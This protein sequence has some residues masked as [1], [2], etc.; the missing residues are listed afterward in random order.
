VKIKDRYNIIPLFLAAAL[1]ALVLS[2]VLLVY[3]FSRPAHPAIPLAISAT[4]VT[5]PE[6]SQGR[7]EATPPVVVPEPEPE[8][9]E[10][11][12]PVVEPPPLV[13]PEPAVPDPEIEKRRAAEEQKRLEDLRTEQERIRREKADEEK[14]K[15]DAE[16]ERKKREE[17]EQKKRDEAE[18]ERREQEAE[19]KR[20][21]DLERQQLENER[22]RKEAEQQAAKQRHSAEIAAEEERLAAMNAGLQERY[23][24]AIRNHIYRNWAPP[25]SARFGSECEVIVRQVPG[26][27]VVGVTILKCDGDDALKRSVE[28]AVFRASPLPLPPDPSVFDRNLR[29]ILKTEQ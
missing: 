19:R 4:L 20:Q 14:R 15:A 7:V 24:L 25:A 1:H 11:E 2:A 3:D 13:E 10:E 17:A 18:R 8:P 27:E 5:E 26:G 9:V 6:L 12:P 16:A 21:E 29:L 28:A 23:I 22:L